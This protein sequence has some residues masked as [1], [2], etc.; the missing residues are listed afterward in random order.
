MLTNAGSST[1]RSDNELLSKAFVELTNADDAAFAENPTGAVT[2]PTNKPPFACGTAV[3]QKE[4]RAMAAISTTTTVS[5]W[6]LVPD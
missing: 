6:L 3:A 1:F 2:P 4:R 5:S